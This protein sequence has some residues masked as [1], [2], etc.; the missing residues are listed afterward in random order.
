MQPGFTIVAEQSI[1]K[2]IH[3]ITV[4]TAFTISCSVGTSE[5]DIASIIDRSRPLKGAQIPADIGDRLGATHVGGKYFFTDK[6][7]IVEGCERMASMGYRMVKLWFRKSGGGYPFNSD[8]NLP[9]T[10][11]LAELAQHPYW[12][13]CFSMPFSVFALSVDG[14]GIRTTDETAAAEE[15]EIYELTKYLLSNY[16]E[17]DVSFI[18]HNWEGDWMLRGGTGDY[19][20]WSR[21]EGEIIRAVDGD[22]YSVLVPSDSTERCDAM[23]KWFSARQRGV[24]RARAEVPESKCNVYHAIE[25]NKVMDS[26]DGLPGL[27]NYVLPVT[28]TDMVSWSCYDVMVNDTTEDGVS[29]FRGIEYLRKQMRPT[30]V[31]NGKPFVFLGEIGIPEQRYEHLMDQ[32]SVIHNWD[33]YMGVCIALDVPYI[34]QWELFC[35]EPKNEELRRLAETR[36]RDEMRGFWLVRPD[37]TT[38]WVGEYFARLMKSAG[39]RL[40]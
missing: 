10:V 28:E 7:Y 4:L 18:L 39:K 36:T 31:M 8:W 21:K 38:S 22:R 29:L 9:D 24:I 37:G 30:E 19:A 25:V 15:E 35:N 2:T 5:R 16:R 1:M 6:P 20:R 26:M 33:V 14:A 12:A 34:I 13:E 11:T 40:N 23:I 3:F 32:Q 27:A 17:R